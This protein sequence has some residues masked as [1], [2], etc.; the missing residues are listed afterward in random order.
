V[1][2]GSD[3]A[4]GVST[5]VDCRGLRRSE[6]VAPTTEDRGEGVSKVGKGGL[7][8][9]VRSFRQSAVTLHETGSSLRFD[10]CGREVFKIIACKEA[11]LA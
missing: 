11:L 9:Q 6:G 2:G 7:C 5:A 8:L 1:C 4:P 10:L 3:A